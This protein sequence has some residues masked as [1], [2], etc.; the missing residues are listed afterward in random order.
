[1]IIIIE[2]QRKQPGTEIII[3]E[4]KTILKIKDY[5]TTMVVNS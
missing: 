1:M 3:K 4:N 5:L 2:K